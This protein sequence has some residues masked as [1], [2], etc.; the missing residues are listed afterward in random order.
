MCCLKYEQ[1]A[2]DE[3][4]KITPNIGATVKHNGELGTVIDANLITGNIIV[5]PK[6]EDGIPYKTNRKDVKIV[7]RLS[8]SLRYLIRP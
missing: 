5:K 4:S 1:D 6:A 8:N 3:L 2:Y 7:S